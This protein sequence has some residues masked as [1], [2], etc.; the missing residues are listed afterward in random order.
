[1]ERVLRATCNVLHRHLHALD[2]RTNPQQLAFHL[3]PKTVLPRLLQSQTPLWAWYNTFWWWWQWEAG[4][5]SFFICL[6]NLPFLGHMAYTS[7]LSTCRHTSTQTECMFNKQ[8]AHTPTQKGIFLHCGH[9]HLFTLPCKLL[10]DKP[11]L[12]TPWLS[13]LIKTVF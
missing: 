3:L 5:C 9:H 11:L 13:I 1:M 4:V 12:S 10:H 8:N 7:T 2:V 6:V